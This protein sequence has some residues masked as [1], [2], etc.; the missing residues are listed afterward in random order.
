MAAVA[1]S[2]GS[3]VEKEALVGICRF[4]QE[5]D[6]EILKLWGLEDELRKRPFLQLVLVPEPI[7]GQ[8]VE[9]LLRINGAPEDVNHRIDHFSGRCTEG[10]P[11]VTNLDTGGR[12]SF[13]IEDSVKEIDILTEA[14][15]Y[16]FAVELDL[17][18]INV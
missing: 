11:L 14:I 3:E 2:L 5:L 9:A 13:A 18:L 16:F 4:T 8:V 17:A 12:L 6:F 10:E 15:A 7:D 1:H